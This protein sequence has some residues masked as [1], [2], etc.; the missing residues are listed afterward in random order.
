M[1]SLKD[2]GF[3]DVDGNLPDTTREQYINSVVNNIKTGADLEILGVPLGIRYTGSAFVSQKFEINGTLADHR[4]K[5]PDWHVIN[6]DIAL[7]GIATLFDQIPA[8]GVAAKVIPY[9]DPFQPIIDVL[10]TLKNLFPDFLGD[11][12][13]LQFLTSN[14]VSLLFDVVD[15]IGLIV[16]NAADFIAQNAQV[17]ERT[18]N[19]FIDF[20]IKNVLSK[21]GK[22]TDELLDFGTRIKAN[23][24]DPNF[25]STIISSIQ[26]LALT[27]VNAPQTIPLPDLSL[28]FLQFPGPSVLLDAGPPPG[29]GFFYTQLITQ[30]VLK[31]VDLISSAGEW[32]LKIVQGPAE[33][34]TYLIE[35]LLEPIRETIALYPFINA[36]ISFAGL[37]VEFCN[38]IIQ[39][40]I[41]SLVGFLLGPGIITLQTA[42]LV[43]LIQ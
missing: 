15:L 27:V 20:I 26:T 28:D 1:G 24:A 3:L 39:M 30:F 11:L 38:K 35:Q 19:S 17:I 29:I 25:K 5:Y 21:L 18:L 31:I 2:I 8:A 34:V 37:I 9:F 43:G 42:N 12:N 32:L 33:L 40:I 13:I 14:L 22:S 4:S 23:L 7:Q 6:L 16:S 41:V 36:A 10:D